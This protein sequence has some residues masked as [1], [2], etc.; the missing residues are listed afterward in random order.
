MNKRLRVSNLH[1]IY[2]R[3][4][5]AR[6]LIESSCDEAMRDSVE[7]LMRDVDM[8][9]DEIT[10]P[11]TIADCLTEFM[12]NGI[13][14]EHIYSDGFRIKFFHNDVEENVRLWTEGGNVQISLSSGMDVITT[15]EILGSV[16]I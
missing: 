12:R 14:G 8:V 1:K 3:L 15:R 13:A 2:N 10:C 6:E 4:D 9:I 7:A 5:S 16:E 11:P